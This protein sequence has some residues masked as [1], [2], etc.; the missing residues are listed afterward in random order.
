MDEIT[1]G[2]KQSPIDRMHTQSANSFTISTPPP[3]KRLQAFREKLLTY[4]DDDCKFDWKWPNEPKSPPSPPP[5]VKIPSPKLP[6]PLCSP[7]LHHHTHQFHH[8]CHPML[9]HEFI[10]PHDYFF[11]PCDDANIIHEENV[12]Q[13]M[14]HLK[15]PPKHKITSTDHHKSDNRSPTCDD[16]NGT[17][18]KSKKKMR[19]AK[20]CPK[21]LFS[22]SSKCSDN[23]KSQNESIEMHE[24]H[25]RMGHENLIAY[26]LEYIQS[27]PSMPSSQSTHKISSHRHQHSRTSRMIPKI[28]VEKVKSK[29][30][31]SMD[32]F[33]SSKLVRI[34]H[35]AKLRHK[36]S[37]QKINDLADEKL[38]A[39]LHVSHFIP[40][41]HT[42]NVRDTPAWKTFLSEE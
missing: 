27:S 31:N 42:W 17:S 38:K 21:Q 13:S 30:P 14:E 24:R 8:H 9:F 3:L 40:K 1:N 39:T 34:N 29:T 22:I 11:N 36:S 32:E 10:H 37:R 20:S 4:T 5:P 26:D 25:H 23:E 28:R 15:S 41:C 6:T 35:A 18:L 2:H 33:L 12:S 19:R 16:A 7:P